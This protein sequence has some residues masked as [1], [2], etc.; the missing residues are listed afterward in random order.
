MER[1]SSTE[2]LA[3]LKTRQEQLKQQILK[4]EAQTREQER[5]EDTRRKIIVG[6][7]VMEHARQHPEFA[8]TLKAVLAVAVTREIDRKAIEEWL[9]GLL[10]P[11]SRPQE[12]G[13]DD[14]AMAE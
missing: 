7:A 4:L 10:L 13:T 6:A 1:K 3:D 5:R 11:G 8:A 9:D 14:P 2:R 12:N